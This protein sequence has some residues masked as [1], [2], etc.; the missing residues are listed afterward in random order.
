MAANAFHK[1]VEDEIC[2]MKYM[3]AFSD[4]EKQ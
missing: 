3:Y 2:S 4:F 1:T